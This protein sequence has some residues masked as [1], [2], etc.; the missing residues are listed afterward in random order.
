MIAAARM[1]EMMSLSGYTWLSITVVGRGGLGV[2][3][4]GYWSMSTALSSGLMRLTGAPSH[5]CRNWINSRSIYGA[6]V[7]GQQ[8]KSA[9]DHLPIKYGTCCTRCP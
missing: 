8:A 1:A 2:V 6:E 7:A 3:L 4:I 5:A 9:D